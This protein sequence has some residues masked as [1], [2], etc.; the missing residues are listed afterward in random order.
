MADTTIKV[1][2]QTQRVIVNHHPYSVTV[3]AAGPIGPRGF[4]GDGE[5]GGGTGP[6][7]PPGDSH[8]P[9]PI[10]PTD[11]G[12]LPQANDGFVSWQSISSLSLVT[13]A[14]IRQMVHITQAGWNALPTPRDPT[15][16]YVIT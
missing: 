11:D 15:I 7:G 2:A 9:V 1:I 10:G 16:L 14:T 5:G 3:V 6:Q 13:S 4:S 8:I 12:K